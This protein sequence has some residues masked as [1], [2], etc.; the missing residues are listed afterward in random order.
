MSA[1]VPELSE[2]SDPC[3]EKTR[4]DLEWDRVLG[5]LAER[6][7]SALGKTSA[8]SLPF[9]TTRARVRQAAAEGRDAVALRQAG[10]HAEEAAKHF[11][12]AQRLDPTLAAG[13][14]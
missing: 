13:S 10:G 5:A 6:C 2:L 1:D 12:E 11:A 7:A 4:S 9:C 3:P 14:R 8:L